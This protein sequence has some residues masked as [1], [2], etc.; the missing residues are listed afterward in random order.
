MLGPMER[1][2]DS[3]WSTDFL[4]C[5]HHVNIGEDKQPGISSFKWDKMV[6]K[7]E[8][9][10]YNVKKITRNW[11]PYSLLSSSNL[12]ENPMS[13][14]SNCSW[15]WKKYQWGLYPR[16]HLVLDHPS[17]VMSWTNESWSLSVCWSH[18]LP[19]AWDCPSLNYSPSDLP[20]PW[21]L[22]LKH[23]AF[24]LV[25]SLNYT[26]CLLGCFWKAAVRFY[27]H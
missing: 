19:L 22:V 12:K 27:S 2:S 10:M 21:D 15:Q 23:K 8:A 25:N 20:F 17:A 24:S 5:C 11:E 13:I 26:A 7:C 18:S 1:V 4:E 6:L 16:G 9:G 3:Y 14:Y